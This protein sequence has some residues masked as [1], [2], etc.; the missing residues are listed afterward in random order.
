LQPL[1]TKIE[2][3]E[4]RVQVLTGSFS[5]MVMNASATP[6]DTFVLNRGQYDVHGEQVFAA[7]PSVLPPLNSEERATRL[8]LAQW[9]VRPD[10]PLTARVA[11]NRIW[12]LFFGKGLV[13][14]SADFGSQGAW[15]SHPELLDWLATEF[16]DTQWDQKQL[17]R[18]IVSSSTYRQSSASTEE[19]LRLDPS[20]QWLGRGARFRLPAEFIRDQALAVSGLLVPRIGGPSVHPYQPPSLW[21]EVSHFGSTPATKQVFVQ[22]Q[23]EKLYRRSLYTFVK[24]TSPH[25]SMTAFDATNREMCIME[26]GITNTP[27]QALVLLND[28]QFVEAARQFA[29]Q[30]LIKTENASQSEIVLSAFQWITGRAPSTSEQ[31]SLIGFLDGEQARFAAHPK[32]ALELLSVGD[33]DQTGDFPLDQQAATTSLCLLLLNLSEAQTRQ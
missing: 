19:Q 8:D 12:A 6:R 10:H 7:T 23:G 27:L 5:T 9:L 2:N 4:E 31:A 16:M 15:P 3:L 32:D 33:S 18:T 29:A 24:R 11:V 28:P 1:R 22:D 25:P 13:T 14:T 21:K 20:N 17:I 30:V 26:R